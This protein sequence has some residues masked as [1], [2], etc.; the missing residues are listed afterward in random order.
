MNLNLP[1][2]N[3]CDQ[4][5]TEPDLPHPPTCLRIPET[6]LARL[7]QERSGLLPLNTL[8]IPLSDI[9]SSIPPLDNFPLTNQL[10][11]SQR[12]RV[13]RFVLISSHL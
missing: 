3:T 13:I 9:F 11:K 5:N 4:R 10:H 2:H 8:K 6:Y 7:G 1:R 12:Q